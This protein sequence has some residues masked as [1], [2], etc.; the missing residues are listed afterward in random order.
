M[1]FRC[2]QR[3]IESW[4]LG[5]AQVLDVLAEGFPAWPGRRW[6]KTGISALQSLEIRRALWLDPHRVVTRKVLG[7]LEPGSQV[8]ASPVIPKTVLCSVC[9][10]DHPLG[11][12]LKWTLSGTEKDL[13]GSCILSSTGAQG[14]RRYIAHP[15]LHDS[16]VVWLD[17]YAKAHHRQIA[18]QIHIFCSQIAT[19]Y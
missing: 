19:W 1:T 9:Y 4:V 17:S 10:K 14:N 7:L 6:R 13:R 2:A 3:R 11:R 18:F 8:P 12:F 16:C 5:V 15:V